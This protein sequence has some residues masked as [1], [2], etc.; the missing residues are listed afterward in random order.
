VEE[1]ILAYVIRDAFAVTENHSL[2]IPKRHAKDYFEL[3]QAEINA[4]NQ[5]IKSQKIH[6]HSVDD[7]VEVKM[8]EKPT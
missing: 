5:L 2:I 1:N 8:A 6:C 4:V 7:L 3:S